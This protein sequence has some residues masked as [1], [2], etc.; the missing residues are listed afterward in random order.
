M[1]PTSSHHPFLYF[2]FDPNLKDPHGEHGVC[3][4]WLLPSTPLGL[5]PSSVVGV[6]KEQSLCSLGWLWSSS[7]WVVDALDPSGIQTQLELGGL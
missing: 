5:P 1:V 6:E 3:L 7:S 4:F 2:R